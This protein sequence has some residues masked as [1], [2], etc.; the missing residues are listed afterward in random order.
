MIGRF[1]AEDVTLIEAPTMAKVL[2]IASLTGVLETLAGPGL[3]FG[4]IGAN[5][6][7]GD[8]VLS[9]DRGVANNLSLGLTFNGDLNL[10]HET[11]AMR[12][13]LAPVNVLNRVIGAI[14]LL[15]DLLSPRGEGLFA[16][17]YQAQGPLD[18]PDVSANPLTAL[19]PGM[20]RDLFPDA[21]LD[22]E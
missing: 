8:G 7:Y 18:D 12:G 15:G 1:D 19:A 16:F 4:S 22:D 6:R 14:P 2:Q 21:P 3:T 9:L 13:T 17:S 11:V 5:W 10:Q 20:L